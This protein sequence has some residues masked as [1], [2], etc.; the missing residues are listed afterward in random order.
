M[1]WD[2]D[3]TI[4]S[5]N[6]DKAASESKTSAL[7]TLIKAYSTKISEQNSIISEQQKQTVNIEEAVTKI[8]SGLIDLGIT[9]FSIKKTF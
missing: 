1:R 8:N 4:S 9:D 6:T 5:Y 3:P 7:E 2:Y